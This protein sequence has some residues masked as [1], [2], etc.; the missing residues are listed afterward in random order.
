MQ[1][2]A[3]IDSPP[4]PTTLL[5]GNS[6]L[7]DVHQPVANDGSDV[8][9]QRKSGATL[10]GL[11][12]MLNEHTEVTNAITYLNQANEKATAKMSTSKAQFQVV[13][14]EKT[15]EANRVR[16]DRRQLKKLAD[17]SN[18]FGAEFAVMNANQ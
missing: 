5:V 3:T 15:K 4:K 10:A 8:T 2:E 13:Q 18:S 17:R 6:L 1:A 14:R 12:D 11:T 16:H 7:R 9:V